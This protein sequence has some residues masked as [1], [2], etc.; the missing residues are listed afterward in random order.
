MP[1]NRKHIPPTSWLITFES[2]ARLGS[3]TKAADELCITPTAA[4]KQLKNLESFLR[5]SLFVRSRQGVELTAEGRHYL[6]KICE[7][8]RIIE[9]ETLHL[10]DSNKSPVLKIEVGLCFLHFWLLPRLHKF[11]QKYPDILLEL[12]VTNN[13]FEASGMEYDVAFFYSDV[14]RTKHSSHLLFHERMML[15]CS[16]QFIQRYG[17]RIDIETIFDQPLIMLREELP[18]WEGWKSWSQRTGLKYRTPKNALKVNDQVAVI[19]A[20]INDAGIAIAWDWQIRDLVRSGQ[21]IAVSAIQE[22]PEKGYFISVSDDT[23]N[24]AAYTFVN[25]V[26]EEELTGAGTRDST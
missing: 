15:V 13:E 7:A 17:G 10:K 26:M 14:D 9:E 1:I 3:L 11:R 20:A 5:T 22:V 16:P 19:Q 25:W 6:D 2:A 4:S 24:P 8:L 18:S 23:I 21:L 12:A